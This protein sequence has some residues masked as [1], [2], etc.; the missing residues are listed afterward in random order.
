[1]TFDKKAAEYIYNLRV[2]I[3][4]DNLMFNI[5]S[6]LREKMNEIVF[7]CHMTEE[8]KMYFKKKYYS[9][10]EKDDYASFLKDGIIGKTIYNNIKR[11]LI[12]NIFYIINQTDTRMYYTMEQ[13]KEMARIM[14]ERFEAM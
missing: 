1:M 3:F 12:D 8:Q 9:S 6:Y 7:C 4:Q 13:K 10:I 14:I 5:R 11:C 2:K